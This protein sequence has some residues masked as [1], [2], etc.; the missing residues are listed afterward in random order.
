MRVP[1]CFHLAVTYNGSVEDFNPITPLIRYALDNVMHTNPADHPILVTE[2]AWNTPANRERMAEIIFEEFN[3]P[4]F[5]IANTSV[6][7]A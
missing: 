5:Y 4:A 3:A 7:N 6:L 1:L 2:P